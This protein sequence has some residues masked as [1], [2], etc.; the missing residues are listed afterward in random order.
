MTNQT[1]AELAARECIPCSAVTPPLKGDD[2]RR[3]RAQLG[4]G[5]RLV[6]EH[7]LEKDLRFPEYLDAAEFT[8]A[9]ARL[10]ARAR[11]HP[12]I[13]LSFDDLKLIIYTHKIDGL[14]ENDFILAARI[15]REIE[16]FRDRIRL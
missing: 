4:G 8:N 5:W 9:V 3:L 10:A 2:L 6:G 7:H 14:H 12:D 11:H 16:R 1:A 13:T 15:D